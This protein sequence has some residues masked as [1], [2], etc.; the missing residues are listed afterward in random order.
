MLCTT[1]GTMSTKRLGD[2]LEMQCVC[3]RCVRGYPTD[4][5]LGVLRACAERQEYVL[6]AVWYTYHLHP[7]TYI[8][9]AKSTV[10]L[11]PHA[12]VVSK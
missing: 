12:C 5:M 8:L 4:E 11:H 3:M 9:H 10:H 7:H 1:P 6:Y 2:V